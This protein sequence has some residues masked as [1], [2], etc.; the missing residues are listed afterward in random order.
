MKKIFLLTLVSLVITL[1]G[2]T[3]QQT[4][5]SQPATSNPTEQHSLQPAQEQ[6]TT[7]IT[8][9]ATLSELNIKESNYCYNTKMGSL[10]YDGVINKSCICD[11]E[12]IKIYC[13]SDDE[14]NVLF[15]TECPSGL[16]C[17]SSTVY[18][19]GKITGYKTE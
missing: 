1:A 14:S 19:Q 4:K 17:D 12:L 7:P 6:G 13:S 8:K 2:C 16:S 10:S 3:L 11:G 18:C 15:Y 9:A 5:S